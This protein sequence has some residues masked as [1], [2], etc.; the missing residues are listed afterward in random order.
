L[1]ALVCDDVSFGEYLAIYW[2]RYP[3]DG[4]PPRRE[5]RQIFRRSRPYLIPGTTVLRNN[6]GVHY[7][8][9]HCGRTGNPYGHDGCAYCVLA[10]KARHLLT[11]SDGEVCDQL[12]PVLDALTQTASPY[13]QIH[14]IEKSQ[15]ARLLGHI[16]AEGRPVSHDL[17]DEIPPS[18]NVHYIRQMLVHTGVLVERH[19]DLERLPAW[20][21]HHLL[22]IPAGH[23]NLIRPYL[24]W[25]LLRRARRRAVNRS[26]SASAGRELRR[27]ILVALE[28]LD[29][30]DDNRITLDQLQQDDLDRWLSEQN[31]QRRHLVRTS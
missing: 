12:L 28:L 24:H 19:E 3:S 13:K 1:V 2:E 14:W 8:C 31:T 10:N 25:F 18:R 23:A 11:G 6:V 20:L 15:N 29:W 26:F 7:K 4:L 21:D 30:L 16:V 22:A 17:L 27:R 9:R 5:Y